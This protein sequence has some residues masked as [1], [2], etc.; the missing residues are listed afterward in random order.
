MIKLQLKG[1]LNSLQQVRCF[2]TWWVKSN[3]I[4]SDSNLTQNI[5]RDKIEVEKREMDQ[6]RILKYARVNDLYF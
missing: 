5:I 2:V 1:Y 6:D 4:R 3:I